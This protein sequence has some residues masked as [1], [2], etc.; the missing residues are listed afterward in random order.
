M[1][2]CTSVKHFSQGP[3][4]TFKITNFCMFSADVFTQVWGSLFYTTYPLLQVSVVIMV[5]RLGTICQMLCSPMNRHVVHFVA[6]GM[7]PLEDVCLTLAPLGGLAFL[8]RWKKPILCGTENLT[9]TSCWVMSGRE[10]CT[11]FTFPF[12][13]F[14]LSEKCHGSNKH[15]REMNPDVSERARFLCIRKWWGEWAE[16]GKKYP[17]FDCIA[18]WTTEWEEA[19]DNDKYSYLVG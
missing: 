5:E 19:I 3:Q 18:L 7:G 16:N 11:T 12:V 1:V 15:R 8:L 10:C 2:H 17:Y 4:S 14:W 13:W 9:F 6:Q